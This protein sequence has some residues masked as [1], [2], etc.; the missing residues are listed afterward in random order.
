MEEGSCD[1]LTTN[2]VLLMHQN[3]DWNKSMRPGTW[4]EVSVLGDVFSL[5]KTRSAKERGQA[6]SILLM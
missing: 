4:R 5:R 1:G 2:G 3:G 6:V